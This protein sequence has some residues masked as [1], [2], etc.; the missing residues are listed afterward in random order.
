MKF[1]FDSLFLGEL[2]ILKETESEMIVLLNLSWFYLFCYFFASTWEDKLIAENYVYKEEI[3]DERLKR[4]GF[5]RDDFLVY[6]LYIWDALIWVLYRLSFIK[7]KCGNEI[8]DD[9]D[10]ILSCFLDFEDKDN[11]WNFLCFSLYIFFWIVCMFG[12]S[13]YSCEYGESAHFIAF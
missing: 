7:K 8:N 1:L 5:G 9:D 4:I 10:F 2:I 11:G 12:D 6:L 3:T 13:I